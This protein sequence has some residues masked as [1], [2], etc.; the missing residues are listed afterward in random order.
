VIVAEGFIY[1]CYCYHCYV[2]V[3]NRSLINVKRRTG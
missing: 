2:I 1:V 3:K